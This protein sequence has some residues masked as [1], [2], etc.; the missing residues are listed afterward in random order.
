VVEQS[1]QYPKFKGF[2]PVATGQRSY[3]GKMSLKV[4]INLAISNSKAVENLTHDPKF[5]GLNPAA[6]GTGS[7]YGKT[8]IK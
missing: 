8:G 5:K 1:T 6:I 3:N 4:T 2:N 7:N